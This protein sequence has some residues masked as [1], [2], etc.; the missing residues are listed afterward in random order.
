MC[1]AGQN[2][3]V[4]EFALVGLE[5]VPDKHD[6]RSQLP[7]Q[8]VEEIHC[9]L[10]VDVG[11]RVQAKVQSDPIACRRNASAAMAETF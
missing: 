7:L 4:D 5:A 10:G 1:R 9:E 2:A 11:S 8:M 6:G 3:F